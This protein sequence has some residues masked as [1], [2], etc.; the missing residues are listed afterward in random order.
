MSGFGSEGVVKVSV[1]AKRLGVCSRT[2]K[3]WIGEGKLRGGKNGTQW[4]IDN[5]S[6]RMF[7]AAMELK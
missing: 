1:A 7:L 4:V 2:L 6:L 3:R 5:V